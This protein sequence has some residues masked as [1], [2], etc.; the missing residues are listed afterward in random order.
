MWVGTFNYLL[1]GSVYALLYFHTPKL[2]TLHLSPTTLPLPYHT[3]SPLPPYL[4]PTTLLPL[5]N[6][7]SP[8]DTTLLCRN[9]VGRW[10]SFSNPFTTQAN[11]YSPYNLHLLPSLPTPIPLHS[12]PSNYNTPPYPSYIPFIPQD[13]RTVLYV[14]L[15]VGANYCAGFLPDAALY[16]SL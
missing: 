2:P 9:S 4:S 12:L 15:A 14:C 6:A 1:I 7:I 11:L 13:T 3:T 5:P 16:C 10:S 8:V